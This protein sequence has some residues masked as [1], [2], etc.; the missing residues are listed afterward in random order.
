MQ[1]IP[2]G[3]YGFVPGNMNHSAACKGETDFLLYGIGPRLNNWLP[4]SNGS[5]G[6][7]G[8]RPIC[9]RQ[10]GEGVDVQRLA[11]RSVVG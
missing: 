6:G 2:T 4:A 9:R 8:R 10:S 5:T 7:T 1:D 3:G 11:E